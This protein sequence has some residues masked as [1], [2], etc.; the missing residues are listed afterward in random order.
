MLLE[1]DG[2]N[3][4]DRLFRRFVDLTAYSRPFTRELIDTGR[5]ARNDAWDVRCLAALMLQEHLLLLSAGDTEE[6]GWVF[7][8]LGLKKPS[9]RKLSASVLK[10]GYTTRLVRDFIREFRRRLKRSRCAVR[11]RNRPAVTPE[12]I[13]RLWSQS[14][15][16]CRLTLG[17]YLFSPDEVI[18]RI[19]QQVTAVTGMQLANDNSLVLQETDRVIQELP[20]YEAEILHRLRSAGRVYWVSDST[21]SELNS[22]VEYP[23]GTVVLVIKPPGSHYEFE[24]KRAGRR[25]DHPLGA[26]SGVPPSHRLD[27]GSMVRSLQWETE[28][29][30]AFDIVYRLVHDDPAPVSRIV[31]LTGKSMLPLN[32]SEVP[33]IEYLSTPAMYGDGFAEMHAAMAEATA[34]FRQEQG[35]L[36]E[37]IPGELGL[38]VQFYTCTG[39]TQAIISGSSSFRLDLV[40][41]YLSSEGPEEYFTRGL[42]TEFQNCDAKWLADNVLEEALGVYRPPKT[43]YHDHQQYVEAALAVPQNRSRAD[44]TFLQLVAQT[45]RMWGTLLGVR[46]YSH[47][48]SFVARNVGLRSVW[49]DGQWQVKLVFQDHDNLVVPTPDDRCS[50]PGNWVLPALQDGYHVDGWAQSETREMS[51]LERIYQADAA[52]CRAGKDRMQKAIRKAYRKTQKALRDNPQLRNCFHPEFLQAVQDWDAVAKRYLDQ[53]GA[54]WRTPVSKYLRRKGHGDPSIKSYCETLE[55][56]GRFVEYY[57]FLYR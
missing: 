33:I 24:L 6:F 28:K 23:L 8:Q 37:E 19:L 25:G 38:A 21:G 15:Q 2:D 40:A 11:P 50:A 47:G 4:A 9:A 34:C 39:P 20:A 27:G 55:R 1:Y 57:A 22:L 17:R 49:I 31:C 46:G 56:H 16:M 53:N 45:G 5:G 18:A 52:L 35:N 51:C 13:R 54:D 12:K 10:E 44:R 29:S 43:E 7:E 32:G 3:R 26:A 30:A 48:E 41:K 14:R 36:L 42:Q